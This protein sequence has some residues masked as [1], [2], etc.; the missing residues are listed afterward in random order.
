MKSNSIFYVLFIILLAFLTNQTGVCKNGTDVSTTYTVPFKPGDAKWNS[1]KNSTDR[2]RALQIPAS[3]ITKIP[4]RQ[5]LSLCL[6]FPYLTD[7][8]AFDD[9]QEGLRYLLTE[10]NGYDELLKRDDVMEILQ[11]EYSKIESAVPFLQKMSTYDKGLYS[12]QCDCLVKLI[13]LVNTKKKLS[14]DVVERLSV[15]T[16]KNMDVIKSHPELFGS[17]CK[18]SIFKTIEE[19]GS[20]SLNVA[21]DNDIIV[22]NDGDY[23]KKSTRS[24]PSGTEVTV[25]TLL[26][27]DFDS[28]FVRVILDD[29]NRNYKVTFLDYPTMK[30]NGHGYAWHMQD[31]NPNDKVWIGLDSDQNDD[32]YRTDGSYYSVPPAQATHV[33]FSNEHTSIKLPNGQY[34]TKL[35]NW[36]LIAHDNSVVLPHMGSPIGYYK[37][38]TPNLSGDNLINS[39]LVYS[40]DP[41]PSGYSVEWSLSD[42]YY[43][44][45]CLQQNYPTHNRCTITR[46]NNQDMMNATLTA[47]IKYNGKTIRTL[48]KTGLYAYKDF[49][50]QYTSD[51]ISG[52]IDYTHIFY[53]KPGSRTVITSPNLMGGATVT[54]DNS[55]I[56][57][58]Y[59][60]LDLRQ[61]K[62]YFTMPTNNGGT[63]VV[64]NVN[65]VLGNHYQLYAVPRNSYYLNISYTDNNIDVSLINDDNPT[66]EISCTQQW[67]YEIRSATKGELKT[68][69]KVNSNSTSISTAG[70]RK[71]IYVIKAKI[72]EEEA[73][74]KI[75]VK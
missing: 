6:N 5:L 46:S 67:S 60:T 26:S 37:K 38:Y 71:G 73:T 19:L 28:I 8:Y 47:T 54:Y 40:I 62:Y 30:Y 66:K 41:L 12:L 27:Q 45:H 32:K 39:T 14:R 11:E 42:R 18:E 56:A 22:T 48:T 52:T 23:Y 17:M 65:D 36:P 44:Q 13:N 2:I 74:E 25:Y 70:W 29:I 59:P 3:V 31:G 58:L 16:E 10:Y 72:G 50:G 64:L 69:K 7:M 1:F 33:L 4:T 9:S 20:R 53:V 15:Q 57:P 49:Y 34:R 55:G 61:G 43:N 51:N 63:P 68:S 35:G 21:N 75:I 24:T